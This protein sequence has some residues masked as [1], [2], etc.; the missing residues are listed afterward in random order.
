MTSFGRD[1]L[2]FVISLLSA[3]MTYTYLP[4]IAIIAY[5][6]LQ[7][8]V[9]AYANSKIKS[10]TDYLLAGRHLGLWLGSFSLFATWFGA[11]TVVASSGAIAAEG[12]AGGRAEP[13]GYAACLILLGI[14]LAGKLRQG[15]Y[16][17]TADFYRER[18]GVA[19]EKIAVLLMVPTSLIW[20]AAQVLAFAHILSAVGHIDLNTALLI[21]TAMVVIYTTVGGFLGDVITDNIQSVVIIIGLIV[22]ACFIVAQLGGWD[23]AFSLITADRLNVLSP[24][25]P[26]WPQIDEWT[27]AIVG[28][29][30]AQEAI[31][32]ILATRSA[33]VARKTCYI[34]AGLY[35][36]VGLIPA[37]IGLAGYQLVPQDFYGDGFL[38]RIAETVL[39]QFAYVLFIGALVSAIL[40]TVNTTLLSVGGLLG[41]NIVIHGWPHLFEKEGSKVRLQ[42]GL[43]MFAGLL[44]YGI[45]A[46][47]QR[48]YDLIE[49]SSSFGSA[50]LVVCLVF[51]LWT[52]RG[53]AAAALS[54]MAAGVFGIAVFQYYWEWPAAY[55]ATLIFSAV[56][57]WGVAML[58]KNRL[59]EVGR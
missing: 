14:A 4:L 44:T 9:S 39:P 3:P 54:A 27:I 40:S 23:A 52:R 1:R 34:A 49:S 31:S 25:E 13:F 18:Y 19:A 26:V 12:L 50:G 21:G 45:A 5:M 38:P 10:E 36:V 30:V 16:I 17:T 20:S 29:L 56:V 46:G 22:T 11:E 2:T 28:S 37:F 24:D 48:I 55:I 43:V 42:R 47:G 32:R 59:I 7:L 6:L 35:F 57:Y 33:D 51:G 15:N 58:S 8:A 53:T 41:H